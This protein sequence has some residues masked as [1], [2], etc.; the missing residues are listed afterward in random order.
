MISTKCFPQNG[1]DLIKFWE[2]T[3]FHGDI[4]LKGIYRTQEL[5]SNNITDFPKSSLLTGGVAVYT[6]SYFLH[7]NFMLLSVDGEYN[8]ETSQDVYLVLPDR[9]ETR[10]INKLYLRSTLFNNKFIT[11]SPFINFNRLYTNRENLTDMKSAS[12]QY[13]GSVSFRNKFLPLNLNYFNQNK[14]YKELKTGRYFI[15]DHNYFDSK[16][17]KSFGNGDNHEL[18][19]SHSEY[20]RQD[21][22]K[23]RT[24]SIIDNIYLRSTIFLDSAKKYKVQSNISNLNRKL[25]SDFQRFQIDENISIKLPKNFDFFTTYHYHKTQQDTHKFN[26]H[27]FKCDLAHKLFLSLAS[28][29]HFEYSYNNHNNYIESNYLTGFDINYIKKIPK[30]KLILNY[31]LHRNHLDT[32]GQPIP[33]YIINEEHILSDD[34]IVL[35]NKAYVELESITVT[36]VTGIINYQLFFDYIIIERNNYV[37]IQRIP[38]G[39]IANNSAIYVNYT[40]IQPGSFKYDVDYYSF[41]ASLRFLRQLV[42]IYFSTSNQDYKNRG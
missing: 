8:P 17:T 5:R 35:F 41:K 10:S 3:S 25:N 36:D 1:N 34:K 39:Q 7:P 26:Q 31:H 27:L 2:L 6:K 32:E 42:E 37:E 40:A 23:I 21:I 14:N 30:G 12:K 29:F 33:L 19:Y 4:R 18:N 24:N 11:I 20:N 28:N 38:G 22:E 13:G 9:S 15:E 16:I